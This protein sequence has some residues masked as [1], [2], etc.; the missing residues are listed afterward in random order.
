VR[1]RGVAFGIAAVAAVAL[2]AC[3]PS[4]EEVRTDLCADLESY[5]S[6]IELLLAPPVDSTAGEVRGALEKVSPFLERMGSSDATPADLDAELVAIEEGF[7]SAL[8]GVGDDE[9]ADVVA[10]GLSGV[11][12]RAADVLAETSVALG[13]AT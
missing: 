12:S 8:D 1:A 3:A 7:R 4:A 10:A 6:T 9:P 5:G 13:C 11:R 2:G